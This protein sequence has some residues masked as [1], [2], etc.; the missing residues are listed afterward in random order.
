[1]SVRRKITW[2]CLIVI[3]SGIK[4]F[5]FFPAA[6]ERY[7]SMGVYLY[8]SRLQ[9][10]LFG[11]M[12]FSFGD[13]VYGAVVIWLIVALIRAIRR[14][15]RREVGWKEFFSFGRRTV[16][17]C[18]WVY[19]LFNGFWGLNYDRQG[20]ASQLKLKVHAYSTDELKLLTVTLISRLNQL[21]SAARISR[22]GLDR[23]RYLFDG[24]ILAYDNLGLNDGR[25]RYPFPSVKSS[26]FS[27]I[28]LYLGYGGYYNPFTGEAQVNTGSSGSRSLTQPVMRWAISWATPGRTRPISRAICRRSSRRMRPS[29]IPPIL[30]CGCTRRPRCIPGIH[31]L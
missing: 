13:L 16:F 17:V 19:V 27:Y 1:M 2:V 10:I 7:Y 31:P 18:L 11:W 4:L 25:W 20:I 5:S 8:L 22:P 26:L 6:V 12:P 14:F 15:V 9:R 29:G 24:A 30:I 23:H 28:G 3:A 21:D